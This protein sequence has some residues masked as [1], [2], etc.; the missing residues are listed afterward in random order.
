MYAREARRQVAGMTDPGNGGKY[1][2][3][4]SN[5]EN[6]PLKVNETSVAHGDVIHSP[7]RPTGTWCHQQNPDKIRAFY[8]NGDRETFDVGYHD[9]TKPKTPSGS[10]PFTLAKYHPASQDPHR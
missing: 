8:R 6:L 2:S 9:R 3:H 1:P 10:D 7:I 4:Y 5:R